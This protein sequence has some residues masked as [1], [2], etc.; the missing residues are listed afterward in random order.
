MVGY[1]EAS[2]ELGM[3]KINVTDVWKVIANKAKMTIS[4]HLNLME[5]EIFN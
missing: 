3:R 5:S 4:Y 1:T 2:V